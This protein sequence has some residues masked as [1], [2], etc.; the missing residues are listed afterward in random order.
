M[1]F[2]SS[3]DYQVNWIENKSVFQVSANQQIVAEFKNKN[4]AWF[5][6]QWKLWQSLFEQTYK[7]E[8]RDRLIEF[9]KAVTDHS[10]VSEE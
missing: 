8:Y 2:G 4:D 10:T 5:F 9:M 6:I 3:C 7:P 1:K